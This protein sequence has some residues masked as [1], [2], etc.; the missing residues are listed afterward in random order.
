L[1]DRLKLED[2]EV[3][4]CPTLQMLADFFA[5]PLQGN[6]FRRFRDIVLGHHHTDTL[7]AAIPGPI[8]DR[9]GNMQLDPL[10]TVVSSDSTT[11]TSANGTRNDIS[12]TYITWADAVK[13]VRIADTGAKESRRN[14]KSLKDRIL[15]KQSS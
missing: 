11:T 6:L 1:K 12:R 10:A 2:T 8:E 15:L 13:G 9:V 5:K 14:R 7:G 4:H 3:Q